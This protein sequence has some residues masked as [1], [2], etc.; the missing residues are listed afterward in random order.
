MSILRTVY[1]AGA[2]TPSPLLFPFF[3][4]SLFILLFFPPWPYPSLYLSLPHLRPPP[5][6]SRSFFLMG[7]PICLFSFLVCLLPIFL[8]FAS[9]SFSLSLYLVS[10]LK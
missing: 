4:L 8:A 6:H 9:P 5:S 7:L 2:F 10:L 3:F 1:F